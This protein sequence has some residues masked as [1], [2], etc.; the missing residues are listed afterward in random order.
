M[1]VEDAHVATETIYINPICN[2]E[3]SLFDPAVL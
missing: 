1:G 2:M 3:M